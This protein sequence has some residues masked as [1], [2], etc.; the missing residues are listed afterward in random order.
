MK[1]Q[2][3]RARCGCAL[4][5]RRPQAGGVQ[6]L[7]GCRSRKTLWAELFLGTLCFW[8][9]SFRLLGT[10]SCQPQE[11]GAHSGPSQSE[12]AHPLPAKARKG[13]GPP[14]G[15]WHTTARAQRGP[16]AAAFLAWRLS[17]TLEWPQVQCQPAAAPG[18]VRNQ[19]R[20]CQT[21]RP[22]RSWDLRPPCC[23]AGESPAPLVQPGA[24]GSSYT[25]K[26]PRPSAQP[27]FLEFDLRLTLFEI[28]MKTT[29]YIGHIVV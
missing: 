6:A 22:A 4:Q 13:R 29:K 26:D 11:G 21:P 8:R 2:E 16:K 24:P 10:L 19:T 25:S 17:L 1:R 14:P 28:K 27:R 9:L 15:V 20:R 23:V 5:A 12:E 18:R 3:R 7:R